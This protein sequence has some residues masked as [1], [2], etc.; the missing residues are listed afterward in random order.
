MRSIARFSPFVFLFCLLLA[1]GDG[2]TAGE[3]S[4]DTTASQLPASADTADTSA[5]DTNSASALPSLRL[6]PHTIRLSAA[7]HLVKRKEFTLNIPE[8][9]AIAVAADGLK[10]LRFMAFSPDRRLFVTDMQNLADNRIGKLY[11]FDG[12]DPAAKHFGQRRVWLEN[13]RNP[14]SIAFHTDAQGQ[15]WLYVALT[16]Q[17]VRYRYEPG[18]AGPTGE[19]ETLTTFPD[20]GRSYREGGWHLTRTVAFGDNGKLYVSVGSSCN[21][22]EEKEEVRACILEMNPDGS[23]SKIVARGL[24]NAVGIRW[25]DGGLWLTNMGADHLG[26]DKP[27][28]TFYRLKEGAHYGWPYA[29]EYQGQV[30]AD[31]AYGKLPDAVA[32]GSVPKAWGAFPAHSAPLGFDRFP[33]AGSPALNNAFLVALHGSGTPAMERGYSIVRLSDGKAAGD[34]INGFQQG[35]ER[36]GRPCDILRDGP[37]SFFF[38]DDHAGVLY[39]VYQKGG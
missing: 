26:L 20:Y 31:P 9:F 2:D 4:A 16:D 21:A 11:V 19:A 23:D 8:G 27:E 17:L 32:P 13:L 18:S 5:A 12:F 3:K 10:R 14:N 25:L 29:Y 39:Y 28:D 38:T 35:K 33:D 22:C 37:N 34:F 30:Y 1:C 7:N 24:R 15:S 6:V 36:V